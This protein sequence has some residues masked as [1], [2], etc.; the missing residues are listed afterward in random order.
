MRKPDVRDTEWK[1]GRGY[2]GMHTQKEQSEGIV[3]TPNGIVSV[4]SQGDENLHHH[5]TLYFVYNGVCYTRNYKDRRYKPRYLK[6]LS[7]R[8]AN[9][10]VNANAIVKRCPICHRG[11]IK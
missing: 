9:E 2:V 7:I 10:I 1:V 3:F 11:K 6:T 4:Y 8:F 5:T